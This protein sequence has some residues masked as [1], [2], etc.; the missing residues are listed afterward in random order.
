VKARE[1]VFRMNKFN[2]FESE[3]IIKTARALCATKIDKLNMFIMPCDI[4]DDKIHESLERIAFSLKKEFNVDVV[5]LSPS[6]CGLLNPENQN[7]LLKCIT[8]DSGKPEKIRDIIK[9]SL[10]P[11]QKNDSK[12]SSLRLVLSSDEDIDPR[13][14]NLS[15]YGLF[16]SYKNTKYSDIR[17]QSFNHKPVFYRYR[18]AVEKTK[19]LPLKLESFLQLLFTDCPNHLFQKSEFRASARTSDDFKFKVQLECDREHELINIAKDSES[20]VEFK[21]RHENLQK[22]F[23]LNDPCTIACEVPLWLEAKELE[24]Y[25]TFFHTDDVLTGH[26]DVLRYEKNGKIGVWDYK[27][28][29]AFERN[30]SIQV[31]LYALMLS[32]RTGI[33]IRKIICGYFDELDTFWFDPSMVVL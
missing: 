22:Y 10:W 5:E 26:V 25:T 7:T 9:E 21:S 1:K 30:A 6:K 29:A 17:T 24:D 3:N 31:F 14:F 16:V 8:I 28:G 15:E 12:S 27:P 13:T 32:I 23:L 11:S 19:R 18:L 20:F 2:Q 33:S 4:S